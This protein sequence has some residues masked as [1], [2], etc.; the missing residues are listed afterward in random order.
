MVQTWVFKTQVGVLWGLKTTPLPQVPRWTSWES[1][2][3]VAQPKNRSLA[4]LEPPR[5]EELRLGNEGRGG[6][7]PRDKDTRL[8]Q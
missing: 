4:A 8:T 5:S 7:Y 3:S 2:L 6:G 1:Q